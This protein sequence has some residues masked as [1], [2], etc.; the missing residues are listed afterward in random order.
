LSLEEKFNTDFSSQNQLDLKEGVKAKRL[1]AA[2]ERR[3]DVFIALATALVLWYGARLVLRQELTPGDLLVFLAYLKNAFKPVRDFAKYTSRLAKASAAGERV[4][5][6]FDRKPEVQDLPAAMRAPAFQGSIRFTSVNF[7][8]EPDSIVLRD[9]DFEIQAGQH[10]ALVGPSGTGKSTIASLILRLYDPI[11]GCVMIDDRDIRAYTLES[12]RRQISVVMQ[13]NL[14][15]AASIRDNIAYGANGVSQKA[16]E[17][18]ARLANAHDFIMALPDGYDTLVGER[19]VTFSSGERQRIAIARAAIRSAPI[20]I[21]DEPTTGLDEENEQ[22]V[23]QSLN[24][25]ARMRKHTTVLITHN[26][27]H[28]ARADRILYLEGGRI[29]ENGT[30][31]DLMQANGRYASLYRIQAVM[32]GQPTT[33]NGDALPV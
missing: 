30:H 8:Y 27:L 9:V 21:L 3:V 15:F 13:D 19:G 2:L 23:I 31:L 4:I 16:I 14:L 5:D 1:A 26:L 28:A 12:L 11:T 25:L 10:M 17:G 22:M 24:W 6:L 7:V 29:V 32:N 18:A 20:L 33:E